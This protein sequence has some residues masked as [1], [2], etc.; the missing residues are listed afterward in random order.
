MKTVE[1]L[2]TYQKDIMSSYG[3]LDA[4]KAIEKQKDMENKQEAELA[5]KVIEENPAK[6]TKSAAFAYDAELF[7]KALQRK[8]EKEEKAKMAAAMK[9]KNPNLNYNRKLFEKAMAHMKQNA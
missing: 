6:A 4:E 9:T 8:T 5:K 1:D 3:I 2:V 7:E